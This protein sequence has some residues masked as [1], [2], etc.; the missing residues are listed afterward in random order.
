MTWAAAPCRDSS[1]Q[2]FF[3]CEA[4]TSEVFMNGMDLGYYD[5]YGYDDDNYGDEGMEEGTEESYSTT[6]NP[7]GIPDF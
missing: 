2:R 3:I 7:A 1:V 5:D 4:S 6:M